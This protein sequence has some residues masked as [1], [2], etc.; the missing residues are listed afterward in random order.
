MVD[1]GV[2]GAGK[3]EFDDRPESETAGEGRSECE[4]R[5]TIDGSGAVF[6]MTGDVLTGDAESPTV[7]MS[8]GKISPLRGPAFS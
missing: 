7:L 1:G 4:E 8:A 3:R 6:G 5:R 2:M